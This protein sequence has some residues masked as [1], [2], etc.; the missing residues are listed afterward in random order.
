MLLTLCT[1]GAAAIMMRHSPVHGLLTGRPLPVASDL[2]GEECLQDRPA[3][4]KQKGDPMF[5]EEGALV[6]C[7]VKIADVERMEHIVGAALR[8][9][10]A[11]HG[12]PNRADLA[13][14]R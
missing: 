7:N 10:H 3:C 12:A 6:N 13:F 5:D 11:E 14:Q 1:Y 9:W 2:T 8:R 4:Q